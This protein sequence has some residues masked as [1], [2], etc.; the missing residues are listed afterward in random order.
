VGT[1]AEWLPGAFATGAP[2]VL[3]A[4]F[5]F[6]AIGRLLWNI[7]VCH[8]AVLKLVLCLFKP[9]FANQCNIEIP[10]PSQYDRGLIFEPCGCAVQ[11][12]AHQPRIHYL[13]PTV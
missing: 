8:D 1:V 9:Q 5:N 12:V 4:S 3:F 10:E 7:W 13:G 11:I 2:E 6:N